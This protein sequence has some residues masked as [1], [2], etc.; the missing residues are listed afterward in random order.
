MK[1][2][3]SLAAAAL[4][5]ASVCVF[6]YSNAFPTFAAD[7]T[8]SQNEVAS[9]SQIEYVK[10]TNADGSY[11]EA[12]RN[13]AT[14]DE[15]VDHYDSQNAL[16]S[17][18]ITTENGSRVYS[19]TRIEGNLVGETWVLPDE[20]VKENQKVIKTSLLDEAKAQVKQL[21][22]GEK[23]QAKG[24]GVLK[25]KESM[26]TKRGELTKVVTVDEQSGLPVKTELYRKDGNKD[27][28]INETKE[29]YKTLADVP[30]DLFKDFEELEMKEVPYDTD[31]K[32][33]S[34][35]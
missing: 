18:T 25:F 16:Q 10:I 4:G 2:K 19:I 17:R 26:K 21:E 6:T 20:L 9:K 34:N 22:K 13:L 8:A 5:V 23:G 28:L 30:K 14:G 27:V 15:R 12:W 31:S 35:G 7:S 3:L 11:M 24:T 29:E 1:R 33:A 32:P